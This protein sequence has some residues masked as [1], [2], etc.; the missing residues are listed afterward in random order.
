[1]AIATMGI[2]FGLK[3]AE[4]AGIDPK[5]CTGF[6]IT[7]TPG[8]LTEVTFEMVLTDEQ[9]AQLVTELKRY[10]L[11]PIDDKEQD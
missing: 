7:R 6:T 10:E 8:S 2:E 9:E 3:L 1:M 4:L 11:V 5:D